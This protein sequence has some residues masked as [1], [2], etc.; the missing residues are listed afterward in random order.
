MRYP[1][2]SCMAAVIPIICPADGSGRDGNG[3][4]DIRI[5]YKTCSYEGLK[6]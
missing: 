6:K 2:S 5:F 3:V 4:S 1:Q